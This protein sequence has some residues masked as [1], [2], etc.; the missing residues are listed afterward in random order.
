MS[1]TKVSAS[2]LGL[3]SRRLFLASGPAGAVFLS[4]R[5]AASGESPIAA[6]ID[7]HRRSLVVFEAASDDARQFGVE[8]EQFRLADKLHDEAFHAMEAVFMRLCACPTKDAHESR[9]KGE[10]VADFFER[11][12]ATEAEAL[13]LARSLIG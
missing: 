3:P 10:Y 2:A 9:A 7:E 8:S 12:D 5:K 13:A 1:K 11:C 6:L 4:L